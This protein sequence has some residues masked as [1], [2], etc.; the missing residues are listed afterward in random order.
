MESIFI[1]AE[2]FEDIGGWVVDQQSIVSMGSSYLMAHGL[3]IPVR[4]AKTIITIKSSGMYKVWVRT[5]NWVASWNNNYFPG[6]FQ[7]LINQKALAT[8]FGTE[9]A[10]WHWQD[11]GEIQLEGGNIEIALHD[12]TGFNGRCD[13]IFITDEPAFVPPNDYSSL[14][15]FRKKFNLSPIKEYGN[16]DLVVVG[17][18]I[19]GISTAI[20]AA[21]NGCKVALIHDREILGG[22]NSSEVRVGL[23]GLIYQEPY[24]ELGRL[25][26]EFGP[27]GHWTLWEAK[28]DPTSERSKRIFEIIEKYPEKKIHNGG[29]ASNYEDALKLQTLKAEKNISLFLQTHVVAVTKDGDRITAVRGV[30][31]RYDEEY[32]FK[33]TYFADCSGDANLGFLAGADYRVGRESKEMTDESSAPDEADNLVMGTSCQWYATAQEQETSFPDCPWAVQFNEKTCKHK[34]KGDWNWETGFFKDQALDVENIRDYALRVIF[35]N[36]SFIKNNSKRSERYKHYSLNWIAYIA[37]KRESRRLLGDVILTETDIINQIYYPDASFTTTWSIDLHYPIYFDNFDEE[38]FLS[39]AVQHQISPYAVPY[40]CLYSRNIT[41]LFMAGRNISVTHIALGTVRVMRTI[42][43]M[44]EVVG[45]AASICK[46]RNI[47]PREIYHKYL[48]HLLE[49]LSEGNKS[50]K[51]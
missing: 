4:D 12:L 38:P 31:C 24:S 25:V 37:G 30:N 21:R 46:E 15:L 48:K 13:A 6:K 40:R 36:W 42:S 3:G 17:G 11:G 34:I 47:Q 18:G 32:I 10:A 19:A 16:F 35:G 23:S 50:H 2:H 26:D 14:R 33:G 7:V 51:I 9:D 20:S 49:K 5:R 28:K 45:L 1:E 44:G 39:R 8:T 27:I 41:N 43:M 22:N 29:P